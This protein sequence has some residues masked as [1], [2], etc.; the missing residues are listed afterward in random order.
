MEET[1]AG[2]RTRSD[3]ELVPFQPPDVETVRLRVV[4]GMQHATPPWLTRHHGGYCRRC[5]CTTRSWVP[6]PC[7]ASRQVWRA[8][9]SIRCV[10]AAAWLWGSHRCPLWGHRLMCFVCAATAH[11]REV[12]R[13]C[14]DS[15]VFYAAHLPG[16]GTPR[17]LCRWMW[18]RLLTASRALCLLVARFLLFL[19]RPASPPLPSVRAH[20]P[21]TSTGTMCSTSS[22]TG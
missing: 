20:G 6:I 14:P 1:L 2:L 19:A 22:C 8:R 12:A 21:R 15:E 7:E 3:V 5:T 16:T 18:V 10:R 13:H 17:V 9:N 11:R 4:C